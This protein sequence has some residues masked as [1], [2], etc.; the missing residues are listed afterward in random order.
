MNSIFE[1]VL[2]S[3][4]IGQSSRRYRDFSLLACPHLPN[5]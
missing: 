5:P 4:K 3:K 2:V 1:A